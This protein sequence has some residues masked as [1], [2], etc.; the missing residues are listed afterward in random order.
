MAATRGVYFFDEF[1]ALGARRTADNDVGEIRRVLNSFLQFLE[2]DDSQSLIVAATN[3]ADLLDRALFRRF[4]DILEY[5]LPDAA[6]IGR[7]LKARLA[8]FTVG[9]IDWKAVAE[10]AVGLSHA[11]STRAADEAAKAAVLDGGITITTEALLAAIAERRA[12]TE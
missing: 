10:A 3:H 5:T 8:A 7:L 9:R 4:D 12:T 6:L 1:D 2:Q 11:E